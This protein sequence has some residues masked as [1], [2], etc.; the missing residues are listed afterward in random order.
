MDVQ[1]QAIS[2]EVA[3]IKPEIKNLDST[4]QYQIVLLYLT[5]KT[6][7][8]PYQSCL[9]SNSAFLDKSFSLFVDQELSAEVHV[10]LM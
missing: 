5:V 6:N 9:N 3:D 1:V 10:R 8:S 7:P 4:V 2:L